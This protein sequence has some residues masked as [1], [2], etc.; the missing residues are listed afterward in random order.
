MVVKLK[1]SKRDT[2][3]MLLIFSD[4]RKAEYNDT[5]FERKITDR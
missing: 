2:R 1:S 3:A 5:Y 4:F